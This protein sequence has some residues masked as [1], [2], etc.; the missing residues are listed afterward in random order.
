MIYHLGKFV[1]VLNHAPRLYYLTMKQILLAFWETISTH[2]FT[3]RYLIVIDNSME[4]TWHELM[5][6][7]WQNQNFFNGMLNGIRKLLKI[8]NEKKKKKKKKRTSSTWGL[9]VLK[10]QWTLIEWDIYVQT[11]TQIDFD[12]KRSNENKLS[13]SEMKEIRKRIDQLN[14]LETQTRR[15]VSYNMSSFF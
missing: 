5:T 12:N 8:K 9:V 2:S 15:D 11:F 6:F 10:E 1:Y 7:V 4:L 14:W 13:P 3:Y